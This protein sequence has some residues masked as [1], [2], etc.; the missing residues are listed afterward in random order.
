RPPV[1]AETD[2]GLEVIDGQHTAIAAAAH[3]DIITIP[4]MLVEARELTER[5][6]AFV[7]LNRDR[8]NI[9]AMQLHIASAA[10][11]DETALTVAQVCKRAGVD[12]LKVQPSDGVWLPGQTVAVTAIASLINRR[13][14]AGARKVLAVLV[15]GR[16]APISAGLIKAVESLLYDPEFAAGVTP[17]RLAAAMQGKVGA[18]LEEGAGIAAKAHTRAWRGVAVALFRRASRG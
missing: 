15:E 1:C 17:E 2:D 14:A 10:M 5:A 12:L 18:I 13:H 8:V 6:G 16:A 4:V 3:P 7:G 9:T 11:G